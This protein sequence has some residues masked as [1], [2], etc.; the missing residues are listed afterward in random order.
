[1]A[2][3]LLHPS[4]PDGAS[5]PRPATADSAPDP[6]ASCPRKNRGSILGAASD[7]LRFEQRRKL[8]KAL[9]TPQPRL[10]LPEVIEVYASAPTPTFDEEEEAEREQLRAAA[11]QPVGF[12]VNLSRLPQ[13][14]EHGHR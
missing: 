5:L 7:A 10:L 11:V 12:D 13:P 2:P 9:P 14:R 4:P 6:T 8:I 1:M 3:V